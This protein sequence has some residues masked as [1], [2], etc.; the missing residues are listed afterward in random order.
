MGYLKP[1]QIIAVPDREVI[2]L[3]VP[4]WGGTVRLRAMSGR[5]RE[6][7]VKRLDIL[8]DKGNQKA[9]DLDKSPQAL[10]ASFCLVHK[11]V[12]PQGNEVG[13]FVQS[14]S[15]ARRSQTT[16]SPLLLALLLL[17]QR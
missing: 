16:R 2:E 17:L 15:R 14:F 1:E 9:L 11:E 4:E 13:E 12:D 3:E 7:Y 8:D 5:Q 10:L 6:Q